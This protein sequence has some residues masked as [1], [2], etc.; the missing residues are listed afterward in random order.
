M[1][2]LELGLFQMHFD[3]EAPDFCDTIHEN[4]VAQNCCHDARRI[5]SVDVLVAL[6]EEQP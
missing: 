3:E 4:N 1:S 5:I 2:R 6:S